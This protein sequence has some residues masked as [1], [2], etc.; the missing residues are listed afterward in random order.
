MRHISQVTQSMNM[1]FSAIFRQE[2]IKKYICDGCGQKVEVVKMVI[3]FGPLKGKEAETKRGCDCEVLKIVKEEQQEAKKARLKRIFEE[4]SLINPALKEATFDNFEPN[5]FGQ[6]LQKAKRYVDEFD[7]KNPKNLFFQ[8]SFGTGKSHLSMA[9]AKALREKGYA[10]IFISTPKLLTKIRTTYGKESGISEEQ[11][12]N[13]LADADLVVFDDIGAEGEISGWPIQKLFE[14][15]DQ[16]A[17][18]HN[19]YTTNLSSTE[20]EVSK[21]LRRIFS[22]MMMNAEPII[23]N[24]TDFRKKQFLKKV[25]ENV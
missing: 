12:I 19:I 23:M 9:I 11:I 4:N 5:E 7:L 17:G 20:F 2:V 24:G 10:T 15:I 25:K 1:G 22:R 6:A 18:K 21:D 3:P 13:A 14:V 16:R 8:G